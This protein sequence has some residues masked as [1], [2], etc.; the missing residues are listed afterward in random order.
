MPR[1]TR[2]VCLLGYADERDAM[3]LPEMDDDTPLTVEYEA[4]DIRV[5]FGDTTLQFDDLQP[6]A[7]A[8]LEDAVWADMRDE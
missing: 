5:T 1:F 7:Q 8:R 4:D 3:G 2:D 6:S